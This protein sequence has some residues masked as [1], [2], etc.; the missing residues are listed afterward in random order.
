MEIDDEG[1]KITQQ[2]ITTSKSQLL[3]PLNLQDE[4]QL[5]KSKTNI[6]LKSM[7][8]Q[9]QVNENKNLKLKTNSKVNFGMTTVTNFSGPERHKR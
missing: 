6:D 4:S 2:T 3:T 8:K 9:G 1:D 7:I 5:A